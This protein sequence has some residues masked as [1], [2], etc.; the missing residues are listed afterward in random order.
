MHIDENYDNI[1]E[2]DQEW[3]VEKKSDDYYLV[4]GAPIERLMSKVNIF[5]IESRQYMQRFLVNMG[6]MKK[7]HEM[8]LKEGDIID[9][10]GYQLEYTL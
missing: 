5:D 7:L 4:T 1:E 3:F 6:G 10:L 9:I 2:L 8:G